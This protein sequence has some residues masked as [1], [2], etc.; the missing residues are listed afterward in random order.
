MQCQQV[1]ELLSA[2]HD[3]EL[4]SDR[5]LVV[6]AHL[7]T[8]AE[9]AAELETLRK[10]SDLTERLDHPAPPRHV[11]RRIES[12]LN[13]SQYKHDA[14]ASESI[15]SVTPNSLARASSLYA[16]HS[17]KTLIAVTLIL[18]VGLAWFVN[19]RWDV[20]QHHELAEHFGHFLDTFEKTPNEAI[21]DLMHNYSGREIAVADAAAA[22]KYRPLVAAGLP[23]DYELAQACL[24][25]MPCCLCLETC[26]RRKSGGML[27]V[28]E[29]DEDQPVWFGD[30]ARTSMVCSGKQTHVVQGD[31]IVAAT[32]RPH[33]RYLTVIG[34][35]DIDE[36]SRLVAHFD[37]QLHPHRGL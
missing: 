25:Q 18:L 7:A 20:H 6:S 37:E 32:W 26:Y 3:D 2:Y 33:Q 22:L 11:W 13:A 8:C 35:K 31:G 10:L 27:C 21:Q 5:S 16:R 29:H 24:L 15:P 23:Q 1:R 30:R 12:E 36:V 9:C 34:A 4:P 17:R 14:P 28:F 19:A